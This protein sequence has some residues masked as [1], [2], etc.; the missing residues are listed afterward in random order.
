MQPSLELV[1]G[2]HAG[3]LFVPRIRR[4]VVRQKGKIGVIHRKQTI[5]ATP[6]WADMKAISIIYAKARRMTAW[7]GEL[8]VVD[9]I[10]PKIGKTVCGLH[11][12]NN[13]RVVH[14][15]LNAQ[16]GAWT[17]PDMWATQLEL[18]CNTECGE[19]APAAANACNATP[20]AKPQLTPSAPIAGPK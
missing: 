11:V 6:S 13:L 16:K 7:M 18:I 17:W 4:P 10:V 8:Y 3:P 15:R 9:H 12:E 5:R 2:W 1:G 19:P 20:T 14:W